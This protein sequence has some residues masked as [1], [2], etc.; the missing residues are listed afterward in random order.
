MASQERGKS[1]S[2]W[3]SDPKTLTLHSYRL[4]SESEHCG[5]REQC[6]LVSREGCLDYSAN[7]RRSRPVHRWNRSFLAKITDVAGNRMGSNSPAENIA[8]AWE[9]KHDVHLLLPLLSTHTTANPPPF[10]NHSTDLSRTSPL[11]TH[12]IPLATFARKYQWFPY[13]LPTPGVKNSKTTSSGVISLSKTTHALSPVVSRQINSLPLDR[14]TH[15]LSHQK[16]E[17]HFEISR[18]TDNGSALLFD[19]HLPLTNQADSKGQ[20]DMNLPNGQLDWRNTPLR[21][22]SP[23]VKLLKTL[24]WPNNSWQ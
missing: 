19:G 23:I 20:G 21:S 13:L 3:R 8:P 12:C 22:F 5:R 4:W 7:I 24:H 17:W 1:T 11:A 2:H 6:R 18:P 10:R 15:R 14:G 9:G 16:H